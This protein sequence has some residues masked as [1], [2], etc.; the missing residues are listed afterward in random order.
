[1][2]IMKVES[3][4]E[5]RLKAMY[6]KQNRMEARE[7]SVIKKILK[8]NNNLLD[9]V[10]AVVRHHR[11]VGKL[12]KIIQQRREEVEK[13]VSFMED[14]AHE[15]EATKQ[16]NLVMR[17]QLKHHKMLEK[18]RNNE[19]MESIHTLKQTTGTYINHEA[20]PARVKGVT[21][22]RNDNQDQLIPFDLKATDVEGLN[23]LCQHFQSLNVDATQWRQLVSLATEM[24]T[25]SSTRHTT[26][27]KDD[28]KFNSIIDLT[29][30]TS[31][32]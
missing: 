27:P 25:D 29:S 13:R 11:K 31:Q 15:V 19:I 14:L 32:T 28:R 5:K 17:E 30:P 23:S 16:R 22:L 20:L 1:M 9:A 8:F 6:D 12:Q 4:F 10:E 18:Q 21:V 2:A 24:S 3:S 26:P 7:A